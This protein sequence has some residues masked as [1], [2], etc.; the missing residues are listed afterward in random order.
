MDIV[1]DK[2]D[3]ECLSEEETSELRP[4][5]NG[6]NTHTPCAEALRGVS[7]EQCWI[8]EEAM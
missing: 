6:E 8:T 3:R 1:L 2:T 5:T 4:E 7:M